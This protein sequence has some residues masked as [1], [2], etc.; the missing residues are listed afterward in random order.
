V[1]GLFLGG[2]K[3]LALAAGGKDNNQRLLTWMFL[4]RFE[5]ENLGGFKNE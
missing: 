2:N 1:Q 4:E 5:T 3:L